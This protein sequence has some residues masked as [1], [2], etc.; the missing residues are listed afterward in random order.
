M[1]ITMK[2]IRPRN[3][4]DCA[5]TC[6]ILLSSYA[7]LFVDKNIKSLDSI[8]DLALISALDVLKMII[9]H[10]SGQHHVSA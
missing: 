9:D 10:R 6:D 5:A 8:K 7:A 3:S 2:N 4:F 1:Q